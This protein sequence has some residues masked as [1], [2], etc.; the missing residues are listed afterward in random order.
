MGNWMIIERCLGFVVGVEVGYLALFL[1]V[2]F[3]KLRYGMLFVNVLEDRRLPVG[4]YE[5]GLHV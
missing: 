3:E 2:L 1:A 5:L 4:V